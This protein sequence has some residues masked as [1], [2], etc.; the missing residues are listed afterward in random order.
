MTVKQQH[1]TKHLLMKCHS[2][3]LVL[4][5]FNGNK[6]SKFNYFLFF[7]FLI[8]FDKFTCLARRREI[9]RTNVFEVWTMTEAKHVFVFRVMK[10]C[11]TCFICVRSKIV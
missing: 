5:Q 11:A 10:N 4:L 2:T 6:T 7:L 8:L 1:Q 9:R 3:S